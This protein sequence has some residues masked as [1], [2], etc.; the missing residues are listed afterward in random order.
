MSTQP[1]TCYETARLRVRH[2]TARDLDALAALCAD[3]E[4]MRF[5]GDGDT[6]TREQCA[7]WIEVSEGKYRDRGYGTSAVVEKET[8]AFVGFCGVVRPPEQDFDEIIYA[9]ARAHWGKGYATEAA[10][11]M[12]DYVFAVSELDA[13]YATIHPDNAVS[14]RVAV[15]IG[16]TF[17]EDRQFEGE[18]GVTKVYV[19]RRPAPGS[20][21]A[22]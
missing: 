15:K 19:I 18:D 8:G 14:G 6:L 21:H 12:L 3:T 17:L 16:M 22:R 13:I 2:F 5:M 20:V 7:R 9:L 11:A 10:R 1:I 4:A